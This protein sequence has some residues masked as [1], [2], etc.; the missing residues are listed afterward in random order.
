MAVALSA[1]AVVGTATAALGAPPSPRD[2]L[3]GAA[4][5]TWSGDFGSIEFGA[6]TRAT[7]SVRACGY[8]P[9]RPGFVRA[10]SD[11]D[12]DTVSGAVRVATGGYVLTQADGTELDYAAYLDGNELH[13]GQGA[14][15]ARLGRDRQGT[16]DIGG[17]TQLH[18]GDGRCRYT[19][20]FE[21]TVVKR[22]C[23]FVHRRGRIVLEY[24]APDPYAGGKLDRQGLVYLAGQRLLVSPELVERP[25]T[26]ASG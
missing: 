2:R 7:F 21:P 15:V 22:P 5:G 18:V 12:P 24:T 20:P 6:G 13:V 19:Q 1:A 26:R 23:A 17:G 10:Y 16:V 3:R 25:F 14:V 11:C 9:L 8:T 4:T